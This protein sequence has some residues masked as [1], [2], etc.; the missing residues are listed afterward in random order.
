MFH[1]TRPRLILIN[2]VIFQKIIK[3]L[4]YN[5]FNILIELNQFRLNFNLS[6]LLIPIN[7]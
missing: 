4:F 2:F 6:N 1:R 3:K 5:K 7:E